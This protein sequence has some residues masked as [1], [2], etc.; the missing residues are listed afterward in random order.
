MVKNLPANVGDAGLIPGWEDPLEKE[1]ATPVF[2]PGEVHEQRSLEGCR[3]WGCK[4]VG[5][6]LATKL[7][8]LL[9]LLSPIEQT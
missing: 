9:G 7:Q 4:R 5:D 1:M 2:L 3:P 8:Q 6:D